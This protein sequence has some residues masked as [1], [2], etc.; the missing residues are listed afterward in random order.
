ML[1]NQGACYFSHI[2]DPDEEEGG[3]EVT[4]NICLS[5]IN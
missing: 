5:S 4:E 3:H 2:L 1:T